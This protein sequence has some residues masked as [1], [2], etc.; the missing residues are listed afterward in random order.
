MTR[1]EKIAETRKRNL[2]SK[3]RLEKAQAE[4]RAIWATGHC[5]RCG[6]GLVRNLALTGWIQCEQFGADGFRK[7]S[8]KAA[9]LFQGFTQ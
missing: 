9:C 4:M 8:S 2:E 6:A 1:K 5:P 7:D 3:A